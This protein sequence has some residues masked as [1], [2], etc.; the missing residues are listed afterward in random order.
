MV[1]RPK[2]FGEILGCTLDVG[3]TVVASEQQETPAVSVAG[4]AELVWI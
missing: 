4:A 3:K 1:G 2:V